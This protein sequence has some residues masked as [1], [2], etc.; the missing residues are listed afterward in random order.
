MHSRLSVA[1][2]GNLP[3]G[4]FTPLRGSRPAGEPRVGVAVGERVL[5][6]S[7]V[8]AGTPLGADLATG[9]LNRFL[10]RG[11]REWAYVRARITELLTG[12]EQLR[13]VLGNLHR[14]DEVR[15]HLPVEVADFTVFGATPPGQPATARHR[16]AGSVAVASTSSAVADSPASAGGAEPPWRPPGLTGRPQAATG[17]GYVVGAPS[18]AGCALA[19]ED[20]A[21]H[22]FGAVALQE[23]RTPDG[24]PYAA[25]LAP[26]VIPLHAAEPPAGAHRPPAELLAALTADGTPLRTGDLCGVLPS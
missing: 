21:E 8:W 6:L 12:E 25:T 5:D 1:E 14:I 19:A 7:A 11:P 13:L 4:V 22:V 18:R 24:E 10:R 20:F 23:W 16:R 26:W 9:S 2:P 3:Y 15:L 17:V